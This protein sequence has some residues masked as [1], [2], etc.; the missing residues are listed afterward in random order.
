MIQIF[1]FNFIIHVYVKYYDKNVKYSD[2]FY[3]FSLFTRDNYYDF[4]LCN[5]R[6]ITF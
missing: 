6:E 5:L 2:K 4:C 3:D 1:F